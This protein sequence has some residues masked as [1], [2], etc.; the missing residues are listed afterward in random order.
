MVFCYIEQIEDQR[1]ADD[2]LHCWFRRALD[3]VGGDWMLELG[4][5][6][7]AAAAGWICSHHLAA[8]AAGAGCLLP[9]QP[10]P[11]HHSAEPPALLL[12]Q[13]PG[14]R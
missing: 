14:F 11:S 13:L 3:A 10:C 7:A 5:D 6:A 4:L 2:S 8:A 9:A 12:L 1:S